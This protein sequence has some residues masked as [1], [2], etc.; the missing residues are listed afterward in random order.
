MVS[1]DIS[2]ATVITYHQRLISVLNAFLMFN[3]IRSNLLYHSRA[4]IH[5]FCTGRHSD[6]C[7]RIG[8]FLRVYARLYTGRRQRR[9]VAGARYTGKVPIPMLLTRN[10]SLRVRRL[11]TLTTRCGC[12]V[13][14]I[15]QYNATIGSL[16]VAFY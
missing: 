2:S 5:G 1:C 3:I 8:I 10:V 16:R 12:Y 15:V 7:K 11:I 14:K 4:A 13:M 6:I 9:F